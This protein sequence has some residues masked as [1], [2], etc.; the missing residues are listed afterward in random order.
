ML[1]TL[2]NDEQLRLLSEITDAS[3]SN[4]IVAMVG[5]CLHG[6][7]RCAVFDYVPIGCHRVGRDT[8]CRVHYASLLLPEDGSPI[9]NKVR[10]TKLRRHQIMVRVALIV[11]RAAKSV[12]G[13]QAWRGGQYVLPR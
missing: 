8:R 9:P 11:V 2:L 6:S 7:V 12:G 4:R 3:T 1:L 5:A 10:Q 13:T